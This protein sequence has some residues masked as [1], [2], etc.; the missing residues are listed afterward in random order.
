VF[1]QLQP[2]C[3]VRDTLEVVDHVRRLMVSQQ[4]QTHRQG[5][6]RNPP[7]KGEFNIWENEQAWPDS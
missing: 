7:G 1:K 6:G 5:Y 4:E 2:L 3:E